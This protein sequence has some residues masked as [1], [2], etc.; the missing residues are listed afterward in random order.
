[1]RSAE[2][3]S[4]DRSKDSLLDLTLWLQATAASA[5]V[6]LV[7]IP[8]QQPLRIVDLP[9]T[10]EAAESDI[11]RLADEGTRLLLVNTGESAGARAAIAI[12][13]SKDAARVAPV[14][15]PGATSLEEWRHSVSAIGA[16]IWSRR[17]G[18]IDLSTFARNVDIA[19]LEPLVA[20][21][22]AASS[23]RVP[24]I[25]SGTDALAA[26]LIA[27]RHDRRATSWLALAARA[28]DPAHTSAADRLGL[29]VV[30]AGVV[31]DAVTRSPIDLAYAHVMALLSLQ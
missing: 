22:L 31:S 29:P 21:L 23:R 24:V 4:R 25:L 12:L 27:Q 28:D 15:I 8:T 19:H 11:D 30:I 17:N 20:S 6:A 2:P 26:A 13:T 16:E 14:Y 7:G 10:I 5:P 1:M 3:L 18:L 9:I